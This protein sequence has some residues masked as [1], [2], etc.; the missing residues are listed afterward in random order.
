LTRPLSLQFGDS[1]VIPK[2][3]LPEIIR[4]VIRF[5]PYCDIPSA[6]ALT[7]FTHY[8]SF[9]S[10]D[11]ET[12]ANSLVLV[13]HGISGDLSRLEEMKISTSFYHSSSQQIASPI[14]LRQLELPH[15]VL[16]LDTASYERA[17]YSGGH[18]GIMIDPKTNK[19]RIHGSTLSLENM[20]RS[21]ATSPTTSTSTSPSPQDESPSPPSTTPSPTS[22]QALNVLLSNITMHNSGNDAFMCLL[23]LQMLLDPTHTQIPTFR[24]SRIGRP[25]FPAAGAPPFPVQGFMQVPVPM[26]VP[27]MV[28]PP[29]V[30]G[31]GMNMN[32]NMSMGMSP[33]KG[34]VGMGVP[35]P[36]A[37]PAPGAYDLA[38]EFGAMKMESR[39]ERSGSGS[40]KPKAGGT[41]PAE[42]NSVRRITSVNG[43]GGG[44]KL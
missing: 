14:P 40:P 32:M 26:S 23:G 16:I 10:P 2:A 34:G 24:K 41:S 25:G 6:F 21:F 12:T 20:L 19:S 39:K 9:A 17:L 18:R 30:M 8:S 37:A 13:A 27:V 15:N 42:K 33:S 31:M 29:G 35:M 44:K 11:S 1:Q 4:A 43:G 38:E 36:S 5:A 28:T 3:K 22:S 7:L